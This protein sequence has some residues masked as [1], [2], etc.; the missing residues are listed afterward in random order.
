MSDCHQEFYSKGE[1][2]VTYDR[3]MS[4]VEADGELVYVFG[5]QLVEMET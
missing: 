2:K 3:A 1:V 5:V 4:S